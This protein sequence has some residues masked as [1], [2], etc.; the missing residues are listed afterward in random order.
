MPALVQGPSSVPSMQAG[1]LKTA[2][3]SSSRGSPNIHTHMYIPTQ[4]HIHGIKNK[5][6]KKSVT[7]FKRKKHK[8]FKY[9][10]LCLRKPMSI[11]YQTR[12]SQCL[13][14]KG[15]ATLI[16]IPHINLPFY[17]LGSEVLQ[18]ISVW[19]SF[20]SIVSILKI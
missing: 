4:R 9:T 13:L 3:Y 14:S 19:A 10:Q 5:S 7:K 8:Y 2:C 12:A 18:C 16:F 6:L 11:C 20:V 17:I 15:N 1:W